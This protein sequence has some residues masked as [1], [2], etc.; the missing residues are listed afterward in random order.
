MQTEKEFKELA[1]AWVQ[2]DDEIIM[3]CGPWTYADNIEAILELMWRSYK[4]GVNDAK[5]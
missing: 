5:V 1:Q 4:E 2:D 3:E